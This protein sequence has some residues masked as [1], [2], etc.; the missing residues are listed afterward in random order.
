MRLRKPPNFFFIH[1]DPE[2]EELDL[3]FWVMLLF[4]L[5]IAQ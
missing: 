4:F 5:R 3:E 1:T 2:D